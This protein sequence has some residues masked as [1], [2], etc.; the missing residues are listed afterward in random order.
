MLLS[1]APIDVPGE[2][3]RLR[4]LTSLL[5]K[6]DYEVTRGVAAQRLPRRMQDASLRCM[7]WGESSEVCGLLGVEWCLVEE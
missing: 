7:Q 4:A 5:L 3:L 1:K 6:C 2:S